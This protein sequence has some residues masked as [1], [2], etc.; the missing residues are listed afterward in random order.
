MSVSSSLHSS[1]V[2]QTDDTLYLDH[3]LRRALKRQERAL[4][5]FQSQL[6]LPPAET[7]QELAAAQEALRIAVRQRSGTARRAGGAA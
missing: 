2:P 1:R 4:D 7:V 6:P 5:Q 3:L